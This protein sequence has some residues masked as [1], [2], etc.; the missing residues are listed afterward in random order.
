MRSE[1]KKHAVVPG[2]A[3]RC[4]PG[5]R[6]GGP[7]VP[8]GAR[9]GPGRPEVDHLSRPAGQP[10]RRRIEADRLLDAVAGRFVGLDGGIGMVD[11]LG[12]HVSV[13]VP[14]RRLVCYVNVGS[15]E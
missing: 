6:A 5:R 12:W 3:C 2:D 1:E 8:V 4:R 7:A 14:T 13:V 15:E 10:A 9:E 11:R